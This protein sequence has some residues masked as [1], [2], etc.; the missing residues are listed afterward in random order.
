MVEEEKGKSEFILGNLFYEQEI[1]FP[2]S[3][4]LQINTTFFQ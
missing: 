4:L 2:F 3:Q 1:D